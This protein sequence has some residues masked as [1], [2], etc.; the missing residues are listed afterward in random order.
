MRTIHTIVIHHNRP[1]SPVRIREVD[2][3]AEQALGEHHAIQ[4]S[5]KREREFDIHM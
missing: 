3:I 1:A 2:P 4:E 5:E